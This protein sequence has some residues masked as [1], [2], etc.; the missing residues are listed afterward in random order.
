MEKYQKYSV[1]PFQE[2]LRSRTVVADL[3][4]A[5]FSKQANAYYI[6]TQIIFLNTKMPE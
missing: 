2:L 4:A 6:N 5:G 1:N 3:E